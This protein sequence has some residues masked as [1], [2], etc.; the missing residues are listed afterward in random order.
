M[1]YDLYMTLDLFQWYNNIILYLYV[2][3]NDHHN[4]SNYPW[5]PYTAKKMT[6]FLPVVRAFKINSFRDFQIYNIVLLTIFTLLYITSPWLILKLKVCTFQ[7]PS[8]FLLIPQ[9]PPMTTTNVFS[10]SMSS[11]G[12][13][14][15]LKNIF[16]RFYI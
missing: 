15:F 13:F 6:L 5:P 14:L 4:K 3:Q 10:V 7:T 12:F 2:L 16:F 1:R 9:S 8:H 11:A